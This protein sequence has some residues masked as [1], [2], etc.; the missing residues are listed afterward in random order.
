MSVPY[1]IAIDQ[2]TTGSTVLVLS[3]DAQVLG[4]CTKISHNISLVPVGS[5]TTPRKYGEVCLM[6]WELP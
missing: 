4:K 5:N 3:K 6:L 1:L 2:G